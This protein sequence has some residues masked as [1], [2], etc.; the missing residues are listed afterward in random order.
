M[1]D[2]ANL[3]FTQRDLV[4]AWSELDTHITNRQNT[5]FRS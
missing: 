1:D 4:I 3:P 2:Q 5:T